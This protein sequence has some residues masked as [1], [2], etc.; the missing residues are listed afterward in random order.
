VLAPQIGSW[1]LSFTTWRGIFL[2]LAGFGTTLLLIAWWRVPETWPR[3]LRPSGHPWSTLA[4]MV[5]I[6]RDRVFLGYALACGLGMGGMFAYIAGS[7]FVLQNV[8]G[9]SPQMYGVVFALNALG[10]IIGAQVNGRVVGRIGPSVLLTA[11]LA[12]MAVCGAVLVV[13]VTSGR[14]G[15]AGVIVALFVAMFGWGF[16]GPNAVALALER[17]PTSAGAASAVLGSFQFLVAAVAAPLAG[18][19]GTADALPM[20]VLILALPAAG[21]GCRVFLAG[22]GDPQPRAVSV[23]S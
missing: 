8:Y 15:L 10:L 3:H 16:V 11:G 19:G 18:V 4:P 23:G 6:A 21:L 7:S 20:A 5:S 1:A 13:I 2:I 9:L 17:Y 12:T 22:P 14:S